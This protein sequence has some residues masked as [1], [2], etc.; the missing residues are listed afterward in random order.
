MSGDCQFK[1]LGGVPT[2]LSLNVSR[3]AEAKLMVNLRSTGNGTVRFNPNLYNSVKVCLSLLR[4][5]NDQEGERLNVL[6]SIQSLILVSEPFFNEP[7]FE[8][9]IGTKEGKKLSEAY[10]QSTTKNFEL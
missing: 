7:G 3:T 10:N 9:Q 2:P 5:W 1:P 8:S 6:M 4:T